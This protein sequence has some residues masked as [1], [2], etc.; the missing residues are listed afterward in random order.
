MHE[1]SESISAICIA[2]AWSDGDLGDYEK[3]ALDRIHVQLGYSRAQI[4]E[5]IGDATKNGPSGESVEI[6]NDEEAQFE[7]MR[8]ALAVCLADGT[9]NQHEVNFL[10]KLAQF[11]SVSPE[12]LEELRQAAEGLLNPQDVKQ[13]D[14]VPERIEALLPEQLIK[15]GKEAEDVAAE[16][17]ETY[18]RK[19]C[20][21]KPLSELL[22]EGEDY[23]GELSLL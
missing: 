16:K 23:G 20:T 22:Y 11:L 7:F 13:D 21:R 10:S 19:A 1:Y 12:K 14:H 15:L 9:V 3:Q 4:M 17:R 2:A 5:R 6:P 18:N 8:L